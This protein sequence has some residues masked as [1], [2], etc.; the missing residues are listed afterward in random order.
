SRSVR[1]DVHP[2]EPVQHL[3][4]TKDGPVGPSETTPSRTTTDRTSSGR[5]EGRTSRSV[6]ARLVRGGRP[7]HGD[8]A[9]ATRVG[10]VGPSE[11]GGAGLAGE[12]VAPA[13][14]RDGPVG[15]SESAFVWDAAT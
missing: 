7:A 1:G 5:Y 8:V 2:A 13:A 12:E 10:P 9:A 6:R 14:T 3:A 15:P 4:A 11:P